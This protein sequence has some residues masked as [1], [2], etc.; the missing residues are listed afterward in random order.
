MNV[1]TKMISVLALLFAVL[2]VL[3]IG[4]QKRVLMPSFAEL[5][6]DDAR[7]SMKRIDNVLNFTLDNLQLNAADWG[8]WAD[9]YKFVQGI[10]TDFAKTNITAAALKQLPVNTVLL[11][12]LKGNVVVASS[13]D[14]DS[15]AP[16]DIDL[17]ANAV[18]PENLPWRRHVAEGKPEKGLCKTNR[19]VVSLEGAPAVGLGH[20]A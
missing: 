15:G 2:I 4:I 12:D 1:R 7:T 5:E 6:R 14:L 17:S 13:G 19:G 8:N 10:N 16:L 18:L 20:R 9:A 3:D 11:V